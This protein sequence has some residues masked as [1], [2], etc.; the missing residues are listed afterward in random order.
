[1][2]NR[3]RETYVEVFETERERKEVEGVKETKTER[4]CGGYGETEIDRTEIDRTKGEGKRES[5]C[6]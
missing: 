6:E 2:K 5:L 3:E 1:M 4:V